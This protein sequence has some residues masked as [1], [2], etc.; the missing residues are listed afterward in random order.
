MS[1]LAPER[2]VPIFFVL[3]AWPTVARTV[4][5]SLTSA[6][7]SVTAALGKQTIRALTIDTYI[8]SARVSV[9]AVDFGM[10][11]SV[12]GTDIS[13]SWIV[14]DAILIGFADRLALTSTEVAHMV[15]RA[16]DAFA[17]IASALL[18]DDA[19]GVGI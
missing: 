11:A 7:D 3:G 17:R 14:I 19:H 12:L 2:D 15:R 10:V 5:I 4:L 9:V 18:S 6:A 13:R 16:G 8:F 1:L